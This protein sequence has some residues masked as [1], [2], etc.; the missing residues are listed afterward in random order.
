MNVSTLAQAGFDAIDRAPFVTVGALGAFAG[1]L[2]LIWL[3]KGGR[4]K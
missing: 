2:I 1:L 4:K 3:F